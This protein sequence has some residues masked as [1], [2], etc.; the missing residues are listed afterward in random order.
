MMKESVYV[1]VCIIV[2]DCVCFSDAFDLQHGVCV[3]RMREG[4]DVTRPSQS[5]GE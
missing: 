4:L 1:C 3:L 2:H 5:H